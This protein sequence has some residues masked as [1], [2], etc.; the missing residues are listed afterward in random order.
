VTKSL[1][2]VPLVHDNE[3]QLRRDVV[4]MLEVASEITNQFTLLIIDVGSTDN[5][6]EVVSELAAGFPQISVGQHPLQPG[7][8][9]VTE[10]VRHSSETT[11]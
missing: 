10:H 3:L 2:F 11:V 1:T 8:Q 9:S 7:T 6:F 5:S 4:R